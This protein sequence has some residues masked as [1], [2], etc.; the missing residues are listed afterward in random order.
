MSTE[1][2]LLQIEEASGIF[3]SIASILLIFTSKWSQAISLQQQS[4]D[5]TSTN[6]QDPSSIT[7][8]KLTLLV[9]AVF[10]LGN[11]LTLYAA[12]ERLKQRQVNQALG[13]DTTSLS[14]NYFVTA[15]S[16]FAVIGSVFLSI[17]AKQRVD[18]EA[19]ITII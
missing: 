14:P 12:R 10:F 9:V 17:G 5:N 1:L 13:K 8:A 4:N 15:G 7:P 3:Y 11:A 2:Q 19:Q 6:T 16:I 18:Q